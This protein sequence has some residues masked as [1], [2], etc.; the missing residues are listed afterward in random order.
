MYESGATS[1]VVDDGTVFSV[2]EIIYIGT[3]QLYISGID[4]HE[5][6]V[7]RGYNG[8]TAAHFPND[9]LVYRMTELSSTQ[10]V[11]WTNFTGAPNCVIKSVY[12]YGVDEKSWNARIN[13]FKIYMRDVT[14]E[15]SSK[16]W[17]LFSHV[18]FNK[19]TYTLFAA[20]DSELILEQPGTWSTGGEVA[21]IT[22][23]TELTMRPIDTYLSENFFTEDTII[24]A[25]Y[26]VSCVAGRKVYIGNIKQGG[27]TYPDRMLRTPVNKFDTFPETNFIDVAIGDGDSVTA[28]ESFG[29]RLLQFKKNNVYI[30]NIAGESEVLESEYPNAGVYTPAQVVKTN[31]G[32]S[33]INSS[34]VWFFDGEQVNNLTRQV[35]GTKYNELEGST[36]LIGFDNRTNRIIYTPVASSGLGTS[37]FIYDLELQAYQ[38]RYDG[39]I[40]PHSESGGNY[41]T[42]FIND[43]KGNLVLGYVDAGAPTELNFYQWDSDAGEGQSIVTTNMWKSKDID[44]ASPSVNKKIYKV[45]VTYKCSGHSGIQMKYATDGSGS[46]AGTFSSSKSTNYDADSFTGEGTRTG[47]KD[48]DGNWEVAELRPSSSI[49]NIKSIQFSFDH[50]T[51]DMGTARGGSSTTIQLR[52]DASISETDNAYNDYNIYVYGGPARYNTTKISDY[53][54]SSETVEVEAAMTDKGYGNAAT[55]ASKYILGAIATDFEINDITVIY[56]PKRV[57]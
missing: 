37:W 19:G 56:R 32:V 9:S 10:T 15:D 45:Y 43:E 16:D 41:Y 33:W 20:G 55:S 14:E 26:K 34:G 28:L 6:T 12:N 22:T 44:L 17:R 48:T 38:S 23:G 30:I 42:N 31:R 47:F 21:T 36:R 49:N 51:I 4:T 29:D 18:N 57:K 40:F 35:E 27:R 25:Q 52:D 50:L 11:D 7:T 53:T 3:E 39:S 5:L 8:S 46:F 24:D 2:G 1:I 13:G 54:G